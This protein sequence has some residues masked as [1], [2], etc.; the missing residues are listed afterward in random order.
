[1][2][3]IFKVFFIVFLIL[4]ITSCGRDGEEIEITLLGNDNNDYNWTYNIEDESIVS[5]VSEEYFGDENSDYE[6]G[7]G[8]KYLFTIK[9]KKQGETI[10]N[11]NYLRT[12][13]DSEE[14]YGYDVKVSV[15]QD[16]NLTINKESGTYFSLLKFIDIDR[17]L[18]GLDKTFDE[19]IFQFGDD[20]VEFDE[21]ECARLMVFLNEEDVVGYYAISLSSNH[22]FKIV[23]DEYILINGD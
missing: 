13:D 17:E 10:I 1:M 2:K 16:L 15:D 19:Y 20:V 12:W 4:F 3:N 6:D 7:L 11:F 8:G 23:D 9:A 21:Y 5:V 14:L 18:L 22:V